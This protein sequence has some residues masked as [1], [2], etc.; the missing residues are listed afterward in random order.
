MENSFWIVVTICATIVLIVLICNKYSK[1]CVNTIKSY[2]LKE[3]VDNKH[4]FRK[5]DVFRIEKKNDG[6]Y[7]LVYYNDDLDD[8][9][10]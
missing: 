8:P 10:N 4:P 7:E 1:K 5:Y 6:S 3:M 2:D 9:Y